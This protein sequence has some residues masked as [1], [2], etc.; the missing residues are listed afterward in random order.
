MRIPLYVIPL[1]LSVSLAIT[2]LNACSLSPGYTV[3][4]T[5]D[6][7]G[8]ADTII[9][10]RIT[11]ATVREEETDEQYLILTPETLVSGRALPGAMRLRAYLPTPGEDDRVTPSDPQNIMTVN[12]EAYSGACNRST[13]H[14]GMLLLLF[15]RRDADGSLSII[16]EPFARTL[17]DVPDENALWVRAV[18][19]YATVTRL[20]RNERRPALRAERARLMATGDP[21]DA[22]IAA[23]IFRQIRTYRKP[24]SDKRSGGRP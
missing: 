13:F 21:Q 3:S 23:D 1:A 18:R 24:N 9:L 6:L 17:E 20:P 11:G 15:L 4:D 19:Y 14:Q 12:P 7:V 5:L 22:L 16:N 10:A 2:P 8:E